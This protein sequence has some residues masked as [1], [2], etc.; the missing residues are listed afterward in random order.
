MSRITLSHSLPF[1]FPSKV[2]SGDGNKTVKEE[3][4]EV[5]GGNA[6]DYLPGTMKEVDVVDGMKVLG[7]LLIKKTRTQ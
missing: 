4:R 3:K 1:S 5:S 2:L 7:K 6:R